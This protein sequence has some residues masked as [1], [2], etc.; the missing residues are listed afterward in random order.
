M[1]TLFSSTELLT[2]NQEFCLEITGRDIFF[3]HKHGSKIRTDKLGA[4]VWD[5]LPASAPDLILNLQQRWTVSKTYLQQFLFV[6]IRAGLVIQK[7][8]ESPSPCFLEENPQE[9][10]V[11]VIVITYNGK[12]HIQECF[13]SIFNQSYKNLEIIAVDN[14][15]T[16]GTVDL[17]SSDYPKAKIFALKKNRHY[18]GGV[19]YGIMHSNGKFIFILNQDVKLEKDC[20][21]HL[22]KKMRSH[23]QAGALSPMMKFFHLQGI[24]NGIGNQIKRHGWG[25]DNFIGLVDIGQFND[26]H[27]IPSACFG[28]VFLRRKAVDAIG[29]LDEGYQSFYEDM[30]WCFRC[31][32]NGWQIYPS[33]QSIVFHKFGA[34]FPDRQKL[35]LVIRNRLRLVMKVMQGRVMFGFI[36]RYIREDLRNFFSL[37]R[38]KALPLAASYIS[39]YISLMFRIPAILWKRMKIFRERSTELRDVD[40]LKKNPIWPHCLDESSNPKLDSETI[41]GYYSWEI[42]N[43]IN[44]NNPC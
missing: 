40:I 12:E 36:K 24:I 7:G 4:A 32:F 5:N 27:E 41:F 16:D 20:I 33:I 9:E 10:L 35:R 25:T 6:L 38:K 2:K 8:K 39:A 26:L 34:S 15:S 18:S 3:V 14:A 19:N 21:N 28:A 43:K 17:I 31:W 37:V 22:M 13:S 29:L 23:P 1:K 42:R 11:S 44:R 30:D